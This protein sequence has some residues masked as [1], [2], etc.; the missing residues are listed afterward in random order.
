MSN[1]AVMT[2]LVPISRHLDLYSYWLSKRN[3]R[4]M[5]AR[6]D[7]D[8]AELGRL[9]PFLFI[10][11]KAAGEFRYR[12]VGTGIVRDLRR[13]LTGKPFGAY[14]NSPEIVAAA[15]ALGE[16]V[17]VNAQPVFASGQFAM[18]SGNIYNSSG[19]LLPLSDDGRRVNMFIASRT[20]CFTGET[21]WNWLE[22][23]RLKLHDVVDI[24]H[25]SDLERHCLDWK[26]LCL[27]NE[28]A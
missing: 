2:P 14:G 18:E 26:G 22:T 9:L 25:A 16:R 28:P 23:A 20:A 12:L 8:P 13:D 6:R 21:T 3:G 4:T 5:P 11:D 17:F 24:H 1:D 15:Q 7:I 27:A 19:L 10:V